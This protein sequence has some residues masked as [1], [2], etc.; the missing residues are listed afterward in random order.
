MNLDILL[1]S[2]TVFAYCIVGKCAI[3]NAV[4][5]MF[6]NERNKAF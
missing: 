1:F 5:V 4:T 6:N 3:S 2:N